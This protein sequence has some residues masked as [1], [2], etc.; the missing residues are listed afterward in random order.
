MEHARR[1]TA[2]CSSKAFFSAISFHTSLRS[3]SVSLCRTPPHVS[4]ERTLIAMTHTVS[5]FP[6][7]HIVRALC[8][9]SS[10]SL[11]LHAN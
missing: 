11:T 3:L 8:A 10:S 2:P 1:S 9:T 6:G 7:P 4:P 5:Y